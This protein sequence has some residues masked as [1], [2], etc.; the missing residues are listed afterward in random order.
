MSRFILPFLVAIFCWSVSIQ[1]QITIDENNFNR[2]TA[3]LDSTYIADPAGYITPTEGPN[4]LWDYSSLVSTKTEYNE[5]FDATDNTVFPEANSYFNSNQGFPGL[6]FPTRQ[7]TLVDEKGWRLLGV[8]SAAI[9]YPIGAITGSPTDS[10]KYPD[11]ETDANSSYLQFPLTYQTKFSHAYSDVTPFELTVAGFGLNQVPGSFNS[12][13]TVTREVTGY[14]N[15]IIPKSDGTPST[16]IKVLLVKSTVESVDSV[17]LGGASAPAPLLAAFGITQGQLRSETDYAFYG[18]DF[19]SSILFL[20]ASDSSMTYR[21]Q[22]AENTSIQPA[23]TCAAPSDFSVERTSPRVTKISWNPIE[24]AEYYSIQI[25]YKGMDRWLVT[26]KIK[27]NK[28]SVFAPINRVYEFRV[29]TSCE[30]ELSVYSS[31]QEYSTSPPIIDQIAQPRNRENESIESITISDSNFKIFPNPVNDIL[32][33]QHQLEQEGRLSIYHISGQKVKEIGLSPATPF[34]QI[35]M[36]Q[37]QNG[38]YFL[39]IQ[40][41]GKTAV[42]QK[43]IKQRW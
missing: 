9:S 31:I 35:D 24:G 22:H 5:I 30:D 17:F 29:A 1:A 13:V 27:S 34:H 36:S 39:E 7:Y 8:S 16:P 26:A 11:F 12:T 23:P 25:R 10:L 43:I 38:S 6:T 21:P 32:S 28:V 42:V 33:I 4:Q 3:Y 19:G 2:G 20:S 15:L 40:E 14:G 18:A 37:L 41:S